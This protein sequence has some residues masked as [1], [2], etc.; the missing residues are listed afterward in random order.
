MDNEAP[1]SKPS[2]PK[3]IDRLKKILARDPSF[4]NVLIGI[5]MLFYES[6]WIVILNDS[7]R[8]RF[9]A[10]FWWDLQVILAGL[11]VVMTAPFL[12]TS[13]FLASSMTDTARRIVGMCS[14]LIGF[15]SA[16]FA[17]AY[18]LEVKGVF[19][20]SHLISRL[21]WVL[22]GLFALIRIPMLKTELVKE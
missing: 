2:A 11:I 13:L 20:S 19:E 1:I 16:V 5:L 15:M 21:P 14:V 9:G 3:R 17:A 12:L 7:G 8:I 22:F 18:F 4:T 10:D 6:L